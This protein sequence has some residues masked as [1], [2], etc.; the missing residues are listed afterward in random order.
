MTQ[1]IV[2]LLVLLVNYLVDAADKCLYN[3]ELDISISS[4]SAESANLVV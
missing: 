4:K 2:R 3:A 1:P